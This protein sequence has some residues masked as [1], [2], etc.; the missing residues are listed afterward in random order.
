MAIGVT[1]LNLADNHFNELFDSAPIGLLIIDNEGSIIEANQWI[2]EKF[3]YSRR[4]LQYLKTET[5]LVFNTQHDKIPPKH[6]GLPAN[7]KAIRKDRSCFSVRVSQ[8]IISELPR[9]HTVFYITQTKE[10][11]GPAPSG[12]KN[13]GKKPKAV[14]EHR[15]FKKSPT[16]AT[17]SELNSRHVLAFQKSIFDHVGAMIIVTDEKGVITFFNH[18][19]CTNLGY[20]EDEIMHIHTPLI[21]HD[22]DEIAQKREEYFKRTGIHIEDDFGLLVEK[23]REGL[24]EEEELTY[25]RKDKSRFPV[26]LTITPIR[27]DKGEIAGY[28]GVSIDITSRRKAEEEL[29]KIQ[30]LFLQLL[31]NYPDGLI[32]IIDNQY[33]FLFTGGELHERLKADQHQLIGAKLFPNFSE[34]LREVIREKLEPVF[35]TGISLS[36]YQL[37]E[38]IADDLYMMDAF[39]LLE[40]DGTINKAGL[41]IRNISELKKTEKELRNS[42]T[43]EKVLGEMKS[44]FVSMASHEFRTPLSTVLSSA[45]LIEKYVRTEDQPKREKHLHRIV[46]SVNMLTDILNDFL[47]LGKIEEGKIQV[48]YFRFNLENVIRDLIKEIES[49]LKRGQKITYHHEGFQEIFSDVTLFK[50]ILLNLISNARKF[51]PEGGEIEIKTVNDGS[52]M[53]L[54]IKDHGIGIPKL[55][56]EHLMTRFFRGTNA[57]NI[58]GTGLGLNIVAKYVEML[59]GS[60]SFESEIEKGTEFLIT[61]DCK[62]G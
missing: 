34:T 30:K 27:D 28:I 6:S 39:P 46:S 32:S 14:N 35:T 16:E 31:K 10:D 11:E 19:A 29:Q 57:T 22:E 49:T 53:Q 18:E 8:K 21:F 26:C 48:K 3:G 2:S 24:Y 56:Q 47:S 7:C 33:R 44:R 55:D 20:T 23:T 59:K 4:E 1:G 25:I 43:K 50:S 17:F 54:M 41:I 61:L 15:T 38:T 58:Q 42:L 60:I 37:P 9:E 12:D 51:S 62:S 36:D 13:H 40:E 5:L 52:K 45:Y